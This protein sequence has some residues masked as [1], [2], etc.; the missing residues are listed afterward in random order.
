MAQLNDQ[1]LNEWKKNKQKSKTEATYQAEFSQM[2]GKCEELKKEGL[3]LKVE[4]KEL[5]DKY[6]TLRVNFGKLLDNFQEY[7]S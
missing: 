2:K 1:I 6:D 5:L 3:T 7:I 4:N